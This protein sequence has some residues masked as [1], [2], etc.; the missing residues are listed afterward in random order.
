MR[1]LTKAA[2]LIAAAAVAAET[3]GD[4]YAAHTMW[5]CSDE[6][7]GGRHPSPAAACAVTGAVAF[8]RMVV[9]GACIACDDDGI[10]PPPPPGTV[11]IIRPICPEGQH[12]NDAGECEADH[13]CGDDEIG[14]GDEDCEACPDGEVPNEDGTECVS[15]E[16]G[17]SSPGV[18]AT[19]ACSNDSLDNAAWWSLTSIPRDP[20][21]ELEAYICDANG[22]VEVPTWLG[23]TQG[24]RDVCRLEGSGS[25]ESSAYG[26][27]HPYFEYPRDRLVYCLGVQ[28]RTSNAI[29]D[30]NKDDGDGSKFGSGDKK[31]AKKV[32][33]PMYLVVPKRNK[34]KVYR[35]VGTGFF[36]GDIWRAEEVV[37]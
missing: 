18:C 31:T 36:G 10:G 9:G 12:L 28:L 22:N 16:H 19:A 11:I 35:K 27:S 26:H 29:R 33:K 15:C 25:A 1:Q 30:W 4:D 34:V 17:E 21:E 3:F 6:G 8:R 14:G 32:G 20:W 5:N 2:V 23:S 7:R 37:R 24:A 13:E